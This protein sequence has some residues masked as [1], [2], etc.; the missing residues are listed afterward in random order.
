MRV[1]LL[2]GCMSAHHLRAVPRRAEESVRTPGGRVTDGSELPCRCWESIWGPLQ[3][4]PVLLNTEPSLPPHS[5]ETLKPATTQGFGLAKGLKMPCWSAKVAKK[6]RPQNSPRSRSRRWMR[7]IRF[8]GRNKRRNRRNWRNWKPRPQG[9]A[10]WPQVEWRNL[11]KRCGV[12]SCERY[13][14]SWS[15]QV[16][17]LETLKGMAGA[18][19]A[20]QIRVSLATVPHPHTNPCRQVWDRPSHIEQRTKP[21]LHRWGHDY[22]SCRLK[23][24]EL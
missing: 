7:K 11:A 24:D 12:T 14:D 6:K 4:Q 3:K 10:P 9:R 18:F 19:P 21:L 15:R 22:R 16:E 8:S 1:S 17:S 23:T 5:S 2:P 13:P 20:S